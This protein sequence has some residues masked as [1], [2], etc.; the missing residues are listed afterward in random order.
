MSFASYDMAFIFNNF[1]ART[2][3]WDI[4]PPLFVVHPGDCGK[5]RI[6]QKKDVFETVMIWVSTLQISVEK[7]V[8]YHL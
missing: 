5:F 2:K 7:R 3:A 1:L 4:D 8:I 6:L